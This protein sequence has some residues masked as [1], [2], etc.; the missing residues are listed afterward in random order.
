[1]RN[2]TYDARTIFRSLGANRM[3]ADLA[4]RYAFR[5]PITSVPSDVTTMA[6]VRSLQKGARETGCDL[7]VDGTVDQKTDDCFERISGPK[8]HFKSWLHIGADI[9][10]VRDQGR[11]PSPLVA[12]L[13][14]VGDVSPAGQM[15]GLLLI[16]TIAFL[17]IKFKK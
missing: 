17:A 8:W 4:V 15:G 10:K 9:L 6:I 13:P 11:T 1:M 7:R 5:R 2:N 12:N 3:E 16:G 14:G